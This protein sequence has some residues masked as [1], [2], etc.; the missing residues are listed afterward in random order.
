MVAED[1]YRQSPHL[2]D[3]RYRLRLFSRLLASQ[4][5]AESA[6]ARWGRI[7]VI[8]NNAG[9]MPL[10]PMSAMK[11]DDWD[12]MVDV[13][14]KGVLHGIAAVLPGML[15]QGSGHVINIASVGALT[16]SPTAAVYCAT[17]M[18]CGRSR[19]GCGRKTSACA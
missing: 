16:V 5:F 9:I 17:N 4:P 19:T 15:A 11:V 6:Q 14:I 3:I 12:R 10:S 18:R 7:D 1:R 13:N 2:P 8:V